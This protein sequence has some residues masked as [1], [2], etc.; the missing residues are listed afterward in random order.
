MA[1]AFPAPTGPLGY[2]RVLSPTAGG[3]LKVICP[4]LTTDHSIVKVSPLC[5]GT[6]SLGSK[7]SDLFGNSATKDQA[8]EYLDVYRNAGGN[9]ID[10][11]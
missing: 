10:T 3:K 9:F 5:L 6:M 7:W 8:F 1:Q 11:A 2:L 4:G